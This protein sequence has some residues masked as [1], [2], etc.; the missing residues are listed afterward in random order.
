MIKLT[1]TSQRKIWLTSDTHYNHKN[2]VSG[3]TDWSD[4]SRCRTFKTRADMNYELVRGINSCVKDGDVLI[5]HGDWSFGGFDSIRAFAQR[6]NP[7]IE[8]HL[9]L[10]NHDHNIGWKLHSDLFAS[11]GK[12]ELFAITDETTGARHMI[13]ASHYKHFVWEG[14]QKGYLHTYGHSHGNA[15][16]HVFGRSMD[17]GVDVAFEKF[18]QYRPFSL[19]EVQS[20]L[21]RRD[22]HNVDHHDAGTNVR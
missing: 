7:G 9:L 8:I 3:E 6:L 12:Q 5:H 22:I 1:Q 20:I 13:F 17:V 14:H 18:L 19:D 16:E 4:P 10:G 21:N 15:E 2:I 11:I